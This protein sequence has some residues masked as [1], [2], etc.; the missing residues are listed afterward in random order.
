MVAIFFDLQEYV[1]EMLGGLIGSVS[2]SVIIR[3]SSHLLMNLT[4]NLNKDVN[5]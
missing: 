4:W 2:S 5:Y 1:P 3:C